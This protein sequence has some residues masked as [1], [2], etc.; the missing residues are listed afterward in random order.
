MGSVSSD[1]G[2]IIFLGILLIFFSILIGPTLWHEHK[3]RKIG[4]VK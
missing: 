2:I 3:Q 4:S 1:V